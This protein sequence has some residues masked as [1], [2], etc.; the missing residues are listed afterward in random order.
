VPS[1]LPPSFPKPDDEAKTRETMS[2]IDKLLQQEQSSSSL[3]SS[4]SGIVSSNTNVNLRLLS[5]LESAVME[6]KGSAATV[7]ASMSGLQTEI[8][9]LQEMAERR[10]AE[11]VTADGS[12]LAAIDKFCS[13]ATAGAT[14]VGGRERSVLEGEG[15]YGVVQ[16]LSEHERVS[17][18]LE[19]AT[20]F[21]RASSSSASA[22]QRRVADLDKAL[23][24]E[25][26]SLS[27]P[28]SQFEA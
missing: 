12:F 2:L 16:L 22:M 3:S 18:F 5:S 27:Q 19:L 23:D 25:K 8:Y 21:R 17:R 24:L 10:A 26:A 9:A 20:A 14:V 1:L 4:S 11:S 13:G 7:V 15:E 28:H 6:M